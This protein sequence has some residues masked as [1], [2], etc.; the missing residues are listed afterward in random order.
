MELTLN[1]KHLKSLCTLIEL[2][3]V[4]IYR[5]EVIILINRSKITNFLL[6]LKQH[7]DGRYNLLTTISVVDF[8]WV[9]NRF[10]VSYD[11]LS[12]KYN[13]RIRVKVYNNDISSVESLKFVHISANWWEREAWDLFGLHFKGHTDLR[14]ILTDYGFEGHPLRKD[15]PLSG[16]TELRYDEKEKK[17]M[18][19]SL[20]LSQ[21][22]RN[23]D[24]SSS[25]DLF[26][27]DFDKN[28]IRVLNKTN[29]YTS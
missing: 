9:Y 20:Q 19:E 6:F 25:W 17:V 18:C 3:D 12:I 22:F 24:V 23:F 28:K 1:L 29:F 15:F 5:D 2:K 8:P 13:N 11:L 26:M 21:E 14:R 16:F 4:Q 27:G 7:M 10:E